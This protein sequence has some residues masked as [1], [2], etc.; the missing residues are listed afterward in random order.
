[1]RVKNEVLKSCVKWKKLV[2]TQTGRKIKVLRY[3]NVG[4]YI[5]DSFLQVCQ[6]E[7]MKRYFTMRYTSQ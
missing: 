4:E 7:G 5:S 3:D 2:K 1:M 6:S